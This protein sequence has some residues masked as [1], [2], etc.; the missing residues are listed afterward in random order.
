MLLNSL[1]QFEVHG[2]IACIAQRNIE[3]WNLALHKCAHVNAIGI[4]GQNHRSSMQL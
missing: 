2:N 1:L 3:E 4:A